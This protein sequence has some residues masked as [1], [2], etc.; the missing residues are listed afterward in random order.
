MDG[1]A[2]FVSLLMLLLI[3]IFAAFAVWAIFGAVKSARKR[4]LKNLA[5]FSFAGI[6][7]AAFSLYFIRNLIYLL[8]DVGFDSYL[9][10]ILADGNVRISLVIGIIAGLMLG[11]LISIVKNYIKN[12]YL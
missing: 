9:E 11:K 3:I 8:D 2:F 12:K 10:S 1:G 7:G 6:I 4:E 5:G